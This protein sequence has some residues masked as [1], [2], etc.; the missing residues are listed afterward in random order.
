MKL[1]LLSFICLFLTLAASTAFADD[2]TK[3]AKV[4][5]FLKLAKIDDAQRQTTAEIRAQMQLGVLQ[6]IFRDKPLPTDKKKQVDEFKTNLGDV[7]SDALSWEKLKPDYVKIYIDAF[8]EPEVDGMLAFYKSPAG[9]AM[10]SKTPALTTKGA[11][12]ARQKMVAAEPA[13]D[14]VVT[15]FLVLMGLKPAQ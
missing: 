10:V 4:E 2:A 14:K 9:Q 7:V 1:Y 15:D 12:L 3:A 11:E 8:S 6:Q 13:I 5:E